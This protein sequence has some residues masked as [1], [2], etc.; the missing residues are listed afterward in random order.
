MK[1]CL[2]GDRNKKKKGGFWWDLKSRVKNRKQ[3][4]LSKKRITPKT[5]SGK[6]Q[7]MGGPK[8]GPFWFC[9]PVPRGRKRPFKIEKKLKTS[10]NL[11]GEKKKMGKSKRERKK[12]KHKKKEK[13]RK[14]SGVCPRSRGACVFPPKRITNR[15]N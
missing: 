3:R 15:R 2:C 10:H 5:L 12:K 8:N 4:I 14:S 1:T 6:T 7:L 9:L 11:F 13:R